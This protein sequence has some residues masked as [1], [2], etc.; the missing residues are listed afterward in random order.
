MRI[1]NQSYKNF[2][3]IH[4]KSLNHPIKDFTL[5]TNNGEIKFKEMKFDKFYPEKSLGKIFSF[6]LDNFANQSSYPSWLYYRKNAPEYIPQ[7]YD[8]FLK[9]SFIKT[10]DDQHQN[11][12]ATMLVGKNKDR[13]VVAG[14]LA[15]PF[16]SQRKIKNGRTLWIEML[17]VDNIYRNNHIATKLIDKV[18]EK[19][20]DLYDNIFLIAYNESVPFYQK[21]GFEHL[22]EKG[23]KRLI[24]QLA[25]ERPDY[26]KFA[27]FLFKKLH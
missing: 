18:L 5:S 4:F 6:F 25:Q 13:Q 20:K 15:Y 19:T 27:S 10:F 7:A 16:E 11:A 1:D 8:W 24:K 14:I 2:N 22:P 21:V 23:H 3:N 26:P 17:A 12:D 9:N